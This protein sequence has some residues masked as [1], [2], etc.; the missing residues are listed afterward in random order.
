MTTNESARFAHL[1]I[2]TLLDDPAPTDWIELGPEETARLLGY[3]DDLGE[4]IGLPVPDAE[5][6]RCHRRM[7]SADSVVE[8][9]PVCARHKLVGRH[10]VVA[11]CRR[12]GR[13]LLP[14]LTD[15]AGWGHPPPVGGQVKCDLDGSTVGRG[16]LTVGRSR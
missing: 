2:V 7:W 1:R 8:D 14:P 11:Y 13:S 3:L 10:R 9:S 16:D 4:A 6:V 15:G 12:C 5:C